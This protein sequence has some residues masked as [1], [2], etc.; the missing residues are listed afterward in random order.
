LEFLL[1]HS[2]ALVNLRVWA[3][4]FDHIHVS[5]VPRATAYI[6]T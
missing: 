5:S 2:S 4:L 3:F 1:F 6:K